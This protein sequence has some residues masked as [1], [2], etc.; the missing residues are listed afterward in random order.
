MGRTKST[1][2][3]GSAEETPEKTDI[4]LEEEFTQSRDSREFD[5]LIEQVK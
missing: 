5:Q 4:E 1:P 2:L 3:L